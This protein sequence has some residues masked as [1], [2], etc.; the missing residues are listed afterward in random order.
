MNNIYLQIP[1]FKPADAILSLVTVTGTSGS[2]PRK[3]GSSALFDQ[4]GLISGTIGGGIIEKKVEQ[5]AQ[6]AMQSKSSG[7]FSFMLDKDIS[8]QEEAICGGQMNILIDAN[9]WLHEE[10]F[11]QIRHS[12]R[13]GIPGVLITKVLQRNDKQVTINRFW[14]T[15]KGN[16]TDSGITAQSLEPKIN[17]LLLEGKQGNYLELS[18][19]GEK[20]DISIFM[21]LVLPPS[22]LII[23]GAGHIGKALV[24]L[25]KLL[26]FEVTIIDER[27]GYA[28]AD[29]IPEADNLIV[30]DIGQAIGKMKLTQDTY[31]VIV[32]R[33]HKSDADA[34]KNCIGSEVAYIGMIGSAKKIA[35]MRQKFIDEGWASNEQWAKIHAPV[36]L[37]IH[38]ESVQEIAVSIAAELVLERNNKNS[39]YD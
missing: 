9:P 18:E 27:E 20:Q 35:L 13:E 4:T 29:N 10:V 14:S 15:G 32:T 7:L 1:E 34:L 11:K 16:G 8:A 3:S 25:C 28:N 12:I 26:D 22:R 2:T 21:E 36:G 39:G 31:I 6:A 17:E 38:S 33:G 37:P 24:H 23:A 30:G 5:L 19:P